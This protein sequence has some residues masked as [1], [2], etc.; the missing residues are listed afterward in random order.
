MELKKIKIFG[1][2]YEIYVEDGIV[3]NIV[4]NGYNGR[5]AA[6]PYKRGA[7]GDWFIQDMVRFTTLKNG[8]HKGTYQ[9]F[10]IF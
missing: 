5:V 7:H 4:K 1:I 10:E 2:T 8:I 6:F 3:A 9:I